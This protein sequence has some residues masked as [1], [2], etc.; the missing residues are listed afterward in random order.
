MAFNITS[1]SQLI[2]IQTIKIGCSAL[3][4]AAEDFLVSGKTVVRAGETCT[5][6]ALSIDKQTMEYKI[7]DL[8]QEMINQKE[9]IDYY[10]DVLLSEAM[11]VYNG[12]VTELNDYYRWVEEQQR[13]KNQQN[14]QNGNG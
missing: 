2:D 10:A 6:K 8:G 14:Q 12:Q 3:K 5:E 13:L 9:M 4:M 1:E 7:T 11:K